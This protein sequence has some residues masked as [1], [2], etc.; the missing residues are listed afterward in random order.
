MVWGDGWRLGWANPCM[1]PYAWCF[2]Q[3]MT[4]HYFLFLWPLSGEHLGTAPK[5][6]EEGLAQAGSV[7]LKKGFQG[8]GP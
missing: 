8:S 7:N 4:V 1:G 3:V 6:H 5:K 2:S